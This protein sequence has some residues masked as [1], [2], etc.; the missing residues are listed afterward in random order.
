MKTKCVILED[1]PL[2]V[3]VLRKNLEYFDN[4]EIIYSCNNAVDAFEFVHQNQVDLIFVDINMPMVNGIDF[5]K[6]LHTPPLIIIISSDNSYAV[7][8][9]ELDVVDYILKPVSLQRLMKTLNKVSRILQ[10]SSKLS[11]NLSLEF[12]DHIFV[13]VDKKMVKIP[14]DDILFIESLKDYVI[15]KTPYKDYVTHYN[16]TAIT[17]LLPDYQFI[18]I[19]RSYTIALNKIKAIDKNSLEINGKLIPM[20]RNYIKKVKHQILNGVID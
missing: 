19:H 1:D 2:S 4:F 9:F 15:I 6:S 17:K 7:E 11:G 14:F 3:Q 10:L 8:G 5:I 12:D 16:L 18:R 13:K 20:G